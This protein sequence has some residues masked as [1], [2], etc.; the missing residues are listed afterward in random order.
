MLKLKTMFGHFI[1]SSVQFDALWNPTDNL[2]YG[3][4]TLHVSCGHGCYR[5][6]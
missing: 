5:A 3:K 6:G 4:V 2:K 1:C